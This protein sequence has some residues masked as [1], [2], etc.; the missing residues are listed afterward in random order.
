MDN[1]N[2][3][4][5]QWGPYLSKMVVDKSITDRLLEDGNKLRKGIVSSL[6]F[7]K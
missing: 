3:E 1:I 4:F 2:Y 7:S 6:P 5:A